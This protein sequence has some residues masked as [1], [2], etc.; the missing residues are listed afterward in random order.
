MFKYHISCNAGV[1]LHF[2]FKQLRAKLIYLIKHF[3]TLHPAI[4]EIV[5]YIDLNYEA[6][7]KIRT[8]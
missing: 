1:R 7:Q 6:L 3:T 8:S 5:S 2:L 4:S